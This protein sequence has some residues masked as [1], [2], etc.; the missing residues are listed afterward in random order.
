MVNDRIFRATA[1][2]FLTV[3]AGCSADQSQNTEGRANGN[4]TV[5]PT[6]D[7]DP[8]NLA[9]SAQPVA[10][11]QQRLMDFSDRFTVDLEAVIADYVANEPD[12]ALQVQAQ[13][14]ELQLVTTSM[15][16]A[17]SRDPRTSL[18]DMAV[19]ISAGQW[20]TDAHWVPNVLGNGAEGLRQV[21]AAAN[22][23]IWEE[24]DL[25]LR[26]AQSADLRALI[27]EW[28]RTADPRNVVNA[29]LRTLDGVELS[30]FEEAPSANGLLASV[31]RLL[32]RVDQSLLT[33]ERMMFYLERMPLVLERQADLTVDRVAETFPIATVNPDFDA[34]IDFANNIPNQIGDVIA[35]NE[36]E[37]AVWLDELQETLSGVE[38]VSIATQ[39]TVESIDSLA[40]KIARLDLGPEDYATTLAA[41]VSSLDKLNR[42]VEGLD[43]LVESGGSVEWQERVLEID[44][45]V[46]QRAL[47]VDR[48]VDERLART[49]DDVFHRAA[50]LIGLVV[51]GAVF[52]LVVARL[53]FRPRRD[54]AQKP[55]EPTKSEDP[56]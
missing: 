36:E 22:R 43:R 42:L 20:V 52:V 34:L 23:E 29:R 33:G 4:I 56:V 31:Q 9:P 41:T 37:W 3:L 7:T 48:L 14:L 40:E 32:G 39:R 47:E 25:V 51:L 28:K 18:L 44:Q 19:F 30:R 2:V 5:A 50:I 53:L 55:I 16:I 10:Q 11:I 38:R 12:A 27:S 35:L 54:R 24:V 26:P 17:A 21:F 1:A 6:V 49:L 13:R 46:G 45:L 15:M 8:E